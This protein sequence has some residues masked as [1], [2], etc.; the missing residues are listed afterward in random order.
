VVFVCHPS[1]PFGAVKNK[2]ISNLHLESDFLK[3]IGSIV[4]TLRDQM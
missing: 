3:Q 2:N 1:S 4:G